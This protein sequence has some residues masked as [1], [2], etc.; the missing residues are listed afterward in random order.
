MSEAPVPSEHCR[1][2]GVDRL[3]ETAAV[4]T[5]TQVAWGFTPRSSGE[6]WRKAE[7]A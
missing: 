7:Q 6:R 4:N 2:L 1:R 5:H 3:A